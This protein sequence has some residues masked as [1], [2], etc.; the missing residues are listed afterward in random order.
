MRML[1]LLL[2]MLLT[3]P[4]FAV[5][6]GEMLDDPV[7]EARARVVSKDLRCVVCQ[8]QSIDE[9]NAELAR[10]MRVLVRERITAGDSNEEVIAYMVSRYGDYVL[11]DPPLKASTYALW[12]GAPLI[13][14]L[15]ILMV[16]FFYRRR[17]LETVETV[18]T[19]L[20][21]DENKRLQKLLEDDET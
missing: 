5:E 8:N 12:F 21:E 14:G 6:P 13:V 18:T 17:P 2:A 19:G 20:S 3:V 4:A 1:L 7:L 10:D 15:G 11:L 16:F 9:S